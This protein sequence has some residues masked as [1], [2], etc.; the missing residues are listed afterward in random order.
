ML[1]ASFDHD[2]EHRRVTVGITRS[3]KNLLFEAE[4][5]D[6][7][8]RTEL[9]FGNDRLRLTRL[10]HPRW[11]RVVGYHLDYRARKAP[12]FSTTG[13]DWW[14]SVHYRHPDR[15][16]PNGRRWRTAHVENHVMLIQHGRRFPDFC[17]ISRCLPPGERK[18]DVRFGTIPQPHPIE[19]G[20]KP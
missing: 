18:S 5:Y 1:I 9:A 8:L 7:D 14:F 10:L 12:M 20:F 11:T 6:A 3:G 17:L 13:T 4:E 2:P 19:R 15:V 16:Y